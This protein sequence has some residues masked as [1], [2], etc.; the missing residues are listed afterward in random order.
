MTG[1]V[2]LGDNTDGGAV[3]LRPIRIPCVRLRISTELTFAVAQIMLNF[4]LRKTRLAPDRLELFFFLRCGVGGGSV[5][6][7]HHNSTAMSV[8]RFA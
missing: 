4:D 7:F 8:F 2:L 6:T 5:S 3:M 1:R